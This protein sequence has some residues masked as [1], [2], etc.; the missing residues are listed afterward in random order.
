MDTSKLGKSTRNFS[1][2]LNS[3]PNASIYPETDH[4][5]ENQTDAENIGSKT[6]KIS[7]KND[8]S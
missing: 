8:D 5:K 7:E 6:G 4:Q 3:L 2:F 1:I